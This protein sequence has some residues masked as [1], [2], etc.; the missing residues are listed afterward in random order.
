M[1]DKE[2]L[3]A[4]SGGWRQV[5][6]ERRFGVLLVILA[7]LL[8][9]SPVLIGFGVS[10][11]WFD[12][13]MALILLAAIQS[14]CFDRR[15]R[16]FALLLGI[17]TILICLG[18]HALSGTASL[19]VLFV[20]HL[21]GVLFFFGSAG[22]IVRSLFNSRSL[23][24]DSVFG[25]VCGY[26]FLGLAWAMSYLMIETFQPGSFQVSESLRTSGEQP[27]PYVLIYWVWSPQHRQ[28]TG[29]L[30]PFSARSRSTP[31]QDDVSCEYQ[32][33]RFAKN[34]RKQ[35]D[36]RRKHLMPERPHPIY[37]S[38]VT[39]TTVGY[40]DVT[41]ISP[42]TRTFA[43][44]EAITGQFYLAIIV[45]GLVSILV[46]NTSQPRRSEQDDTG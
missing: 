22:L 11:G 18:G 24:F 30:M 17:P 21:C 13:L 38:F 3:W 2:P 1:A 5:Y 4:K 40:G 15:Q 32:L 6:S 29:N 23:T 20:G 45:A 46:A 14:L 10:A 19:S 16:M 42:T 37:Y 25:A 7:V 39:L 36:Q 28:N 43:W 33:G 27:Q 31:P 35:Q 8:A 26:L 44:I 12:G 9:G 34:R 41:P